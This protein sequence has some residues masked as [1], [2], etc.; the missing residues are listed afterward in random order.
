MD[1]EQAVQIVRQKLK[2]PR[3]EHT[4][5]VVDAAIELA[6]RY[7]V[8]KDQAKLAAIFHDY[9]KLMPIN[10]LREVLLESNED[11]RL[12]TYHPELWHGPAAAYLLSKDYHIS[13]VDVL[14]SIRFHTTGRSNM[15][16]LEKVVFLADYIEPGRNF[17]GVDE[18]RNL[19]NT[20]L[21]AAVL[22][23]LSNTIAFLAQKKRAIFPDTVEAKRY[24]A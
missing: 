23:A 10:E 5:G 1:Y 3:L 9:A 22:Q 11:E 12:L 6:E 4:F 16:L 20:D 8:N 17:P 15:T 19:A 24:P 13:D 7:G 18:T 2:G 14:N 21:N